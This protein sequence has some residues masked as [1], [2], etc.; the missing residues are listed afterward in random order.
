MKPL[1]QFG[2]EEQER[3]LPASLKVASR[4]WQSPKRPLVDARA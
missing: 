3:L 4:R 1:I 2:T